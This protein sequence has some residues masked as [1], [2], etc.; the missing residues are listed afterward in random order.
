[1]NAILALEDGTIFNGTSFGADG[2]RVGELVFNTSMS[3]YQEI[4]TDPSY[5]EQIVTMT[6]PLIGNY[7]VNP[8]DVESDRVQVQGFV[9]KE[10]CR[11]PSNYRSTQTL[12]DYL[13]AAGVIA[14]EGVDTRMITRRIRTG[15]AMK[16]CISTVD[17]DP[18]S[19]VAKAKGYA[20][21]AGR[22]LVPEVTC[23]KAYTWNKDHRNPKTWRVA[24][25][26]FG[27][28]WNILRLL[29]ARGCDL[30]VFPATATADE[31]AA[32]DPDG[33][34]LSNGPGDPAAVTYAIAGIRK[35]LE[36]QPIF[37]ICL[38]HQLLG[39]AFGGRTYKLKFGHRGG[40]QPVIDLRTG[41]IDI[42]A[43]NHGF[44]VDPDSLKGKAVEI[45]HLNCN[46][47]TVEG[48]RHTELP[49]FSVQYHPESSPGPHDARYLFDAFIAD[50]RNAKKK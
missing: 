29:E 45:T 44:A 25:Y 31:I 13:K 43:Q 10:A 1:M 33:L 26:D 38:G 49:I 36:R 50:M 18:A 16:V 8:D 34:F 46:D 30:T 9:V 11:Y 21:M 41:K 40:N 39:H 2:E 32:I 19:A 47:Q 6:Y 20:G 37:G 12:G 5:R 28:K 3:G 22:D 27:I 24:V 23:P 42:T 4:L 35:L 48:M 17:L 15:G 7:G 14:I